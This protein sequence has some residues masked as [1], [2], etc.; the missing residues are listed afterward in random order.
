VPDGETPVL[1]TAGDHTM[2]LLG[3]PL[4]IIVRLRKFGMYVAGFS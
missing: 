3:S 2:Q 4:R 1:P